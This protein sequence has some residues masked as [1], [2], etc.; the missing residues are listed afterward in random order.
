MAHEDRIR[1]EVNKTLRWFD[2]DKISGEDPLLLTRIQ[3]ALIGQPG[4]RRRRFGPALSLEYLG[5]LLLLALNLLAAI[6]YER[7]AEA[8]AH[9]KILSELQEDLQLDEFMSDF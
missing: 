1:E 8:E 2:E 3:A 4:R 7:H 6:F 9:T 5:I